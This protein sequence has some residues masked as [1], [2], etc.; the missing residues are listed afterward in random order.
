MLVLVNSVYIKLCQV[1]LGYSTL[2]RVNSGCKF[3]SV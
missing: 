3:S 2:F 1:I